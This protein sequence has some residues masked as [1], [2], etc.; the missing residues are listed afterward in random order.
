MSNIHFYF[1]FVQYIASVTSSILQCPGKE[2]KKKHAD[3]GL[4]LETFQM[5]KP[6]LEH[7]EDLKLDK[8]YTR[9]LY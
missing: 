9:Q 3:L 2:T 5:W 1:L 7:S 4:L 6:R 8:G